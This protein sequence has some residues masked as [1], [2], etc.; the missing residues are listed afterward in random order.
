MLFKSILPLYLLLLFG[1]QAFAKGPNL[2]MGI[3]KEAKFTKMRQDT[4]FS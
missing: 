3:Y 2:V 1:L 4:Y